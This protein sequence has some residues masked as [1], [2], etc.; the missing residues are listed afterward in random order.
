MDEKELTKVVA[1]EK[2]LLDPAVRRS[3]DKVTALLHPDFVQYG[4]AGYRLNTEKLLAALAENPEPPGE[5]SDF[6]ALRLAPDAILVTY[7]ISGPT[8][9]RRISTWVRE[10][11]GGWLRHFH[12]AAPLG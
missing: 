1:L 9:S 8:P 10:Q 4:T 7:R 2:R 3:P 5:A 11:E 6:G 12:Q